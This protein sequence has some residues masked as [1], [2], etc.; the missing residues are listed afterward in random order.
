MVNEP[1]F[2]GL[3]LETR[4][5]IYS[6]CLLN[7]R[8]L[9]MINDDMHH[10]TRA[11][12]LTNRQINREVLS[13]YYAKNTFQLS[14]ISANYHP[15][16]RSRK[17]FLDARLSRVRNL[18]LV[19]RTSEEQRASTAIGDVHV[20]FPSIS[21]FPKQQQQWYWFVDTLNR[22][23]SGQDGFWLS[24]LKIRDS[25]LDS[26][27]LERQRV[28]VLGEEGDEVVPPYSFLL[29]GVRERI[30]RVE[31]EQMTEAQQ[32]EAETDQDLTTSGVVEPIT[33]EGASQGVRA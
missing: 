8:A 13:F 11:L 23:K 10:L 18:R 15:K 19:V 33:S 30:G 26:G 31:I 22:V 24:T 6:H 14:L 4:Q 20:Y 16:E 32:I 28:I 2:L 7:T 9:D 1:T 25:G 5:H 3:P 12:V 17:I 27:V 29:E 21:K